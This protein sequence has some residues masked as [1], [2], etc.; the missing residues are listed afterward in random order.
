[1]IRLLNAL[2]RT[3]VVACSGGLDSM[4]ALDFLRRRHHTQ[5][6]FFD[7]GTVASEHGLATVRTYCSQ[8][9]I[10]LA[11]GKISQPRPPGISPE[12]HWRNE[13]YGFLDRLPGSE[14]VVLAHHLDDA[15][16]TWIWGSCHGQP[17]IMNYQRGRCVRPFLRTPKQQLVAWTQRHAVTWY[18]DHSNRDLR[19]SRNQIR[20]AVMPEILK[21]NP[22]IATMVQRKILDKN[23]RHWL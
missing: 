15:V 2:P 1:M 4:A 10:P 9:D 5:V 6:A 13:R 19:Y 23:Q 16:E 18:E 22:G 20:H 8:H 7:H 12:E 3:V 11:I 21:V 14:P 17:R